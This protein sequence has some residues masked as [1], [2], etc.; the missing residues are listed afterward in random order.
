MPPSV[1]ADPPVVG[2]GR[3]PATAALPLTGLTRWIT[4]VIPAGVC[5]P[6]TQIWPPETATAAYR[7]GTGNLATVRNRWPSVVARTASS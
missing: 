2:C 7:T 1:N 5:P 6:K 4:L 3:W